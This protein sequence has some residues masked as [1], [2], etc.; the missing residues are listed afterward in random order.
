M[1]SESAPHAQAVFT[2]FDR[3]EDGTVDINEFAMRIRGEMKPSRVKMVKEI[4]D[5]LDK[6]GDSLVTVEDLRGVYV[7]PGNMDPEAALQGFDDFVTSW[8]QLPEISRKQWSY[9]G[10]LFSREEDVPLAAQHIPPTLVPIECSDL[11]I[12]TDCLAVQENHVLAAA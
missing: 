7:V 4:F 11:K 3:S 6:T 1:L 9:M 2:F 12:H 10:G 8:M 5:S